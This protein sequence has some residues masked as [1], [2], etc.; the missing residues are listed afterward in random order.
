MKQA[1]RKQADTAQAAYL[2]K[3]THDCLHILV[4]CQVLQQ[5]CHSCH[6]LISTLYVAPAP[7]V[8][9]SQ[10]QMKCTVGPQGGTSTKFPLF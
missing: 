8:H 3:L 2:S 7:T 9:D 10:Q 5:H 4:W 6:G 1:A